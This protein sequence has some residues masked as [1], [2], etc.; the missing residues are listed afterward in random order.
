M[1]TIII[2]NENLRDIITDKHILNYI[3]SDND[4][5]TYYQGNVNEKEEFHGYGKIIYKERIK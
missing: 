3:L 5:Q 1:S 2:N 4:M